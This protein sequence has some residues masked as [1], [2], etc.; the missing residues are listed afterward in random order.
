M[1]NRIPLRFFVVTFLWSWLIWAAL[2]FTGAGIIPYGFLTKISLPVMLLGA[3][4]PVVGTFVSLYSLEGKGAMKK[5][6][7]IYLSLNFGWKA[8]LAI[9]L[10]LTAA[11]FIAWILPEFFGSDRLPAILPVSFII[12]YLLLMIFLGGGQEEVG[13]RAY[14]LP[15]FEKKFGLI[16][17]SLILGIIWAVWHIPL[18]FI[19]G[20]AQSYMNFLGFTFLCIGY[21][22]FFSW[23]IKA[24]G[25]RFFSGLIVHGVANTVV[26][27]FPFLIMEDNVKQIR[28]WIYCL[29]ILI[30][31]VIIVIIRTI[32]AKK[33]QLTNSN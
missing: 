25:N 5:H 17:G 19:P 21:S 4:G 13:W 32:E 8:W 23:V 2:V 22:Y 24:S 10:V 29:L 6:L 20:T 12:P 15:I 18:W 27:V 16:I 3:F 30:I 7:K 26:V 31:G 33:K 14:I 9:L 28:Y 1:E 11:A